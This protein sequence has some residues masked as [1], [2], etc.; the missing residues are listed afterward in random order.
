[1]KFLCLRYYYYYYQLVVLWRMCV[2]CVDNSKYD[3]CRVRVSLCYVWREE[4]I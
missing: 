3:G 4:S 1:M 2:A